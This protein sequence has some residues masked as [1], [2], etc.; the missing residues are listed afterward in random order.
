MHYAFEAWTQRHSPRRSFARHS[1]DAVV[2]CRSQ[3]QAQVDMRAIASW[4]AD[5][6]WLNVD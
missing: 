4:L 5:H 3:E 1:Y 6:G 2:H